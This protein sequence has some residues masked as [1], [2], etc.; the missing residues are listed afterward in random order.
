MRRPTGGRTDSRVHSLGSGASISHRGSG[1]RE[2]PT[3]FNRQPVGGSDY[4]SVTQ[5]SLALLTRWM[6]LNRVP[7]VAL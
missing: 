5:P 4:S 2:T 1:M 3:E 6:Y 7:R